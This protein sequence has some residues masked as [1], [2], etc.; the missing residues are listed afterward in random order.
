MVLPSRAR[1]LDRE[2]EGIGVDVRTREA[3]R[4]RAFGRIIVEA[5]TLAGLMALPATAQGPDCIVIDDFSTGTVGQ[6]PTE[7]KARKDEGR[8]VYVVLEEGGNRFMRA[9]SKGLGIQAARA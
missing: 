1:A 8:E 3:Q 5:L 2:P 7:W 6:F 4:M 9:V